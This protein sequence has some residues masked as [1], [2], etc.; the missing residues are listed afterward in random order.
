MHVTGGLRA[1]GGIKEKVQA[2]C[3]FGTIKT[4]VVPQG[5]TQAGVMACLPACLP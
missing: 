4:V 1:V 2:A 3:A 5:N